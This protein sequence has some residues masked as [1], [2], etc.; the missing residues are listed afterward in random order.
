MHAVVMES[1]EDFL[2]GTLEPAERKA[3][4]SHLSACSMC[5]EEVSGFQDISPL[6]GC[7]RADDP[8]AP[9]PGFYARVMQG[10]EAQKR[11]S[12]FNFLDL[13]AARRMAFASLLTMA[14]IAGFLVSRDHSSAPGYT[15][16][17]VMAQQNLPAFDSA[18]PDNM[19]VTLTSY[20]R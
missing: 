7:L 16:D 9:A 15:P 6:F 19:L 17:S 8:A 2:S 18:S 11:Q 14:A 13:S 5:R 10:M 12:F 3:I 20:E 4:E 1:L